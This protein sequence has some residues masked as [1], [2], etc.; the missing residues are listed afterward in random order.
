M[1]ADS[2][3]ASL[4]RLR[5]EVLDEMDQAEREFSAVRMRV[6]RMESDLRIGLPEP[7]GYAQA[8]GHDLPAAEQRVLDLFR[9][10]LKL[11]DKIKLA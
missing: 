11:E 1:A 9:Q 7:A 4:L 5:D 8:K 10:L 3:P 2:P 6:E